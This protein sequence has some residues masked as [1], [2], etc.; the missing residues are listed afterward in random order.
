MAAEVV[1]WLE[2]EGWDVYQEVSGPSGVCDIVAIRDGRCRVVEAKLAMGLPVLHQ[3]NGWLP[4]AHEVCVAVPACGWKTPP[5]F[6][7]GLTVAR[8]FGF[9]VVHVCKRRGAR[10]AVP[11]KEQDALYV[12]KLTKLLHPKMKTFSP[13]GTSSGKRYTP[14]KETA[15]RVLAYVTANPGVDIQALAQG[16]THHYKKNRTF[17]QCIPKLV[18]QGAVPGVKVEH[19]EKAQTLR[20]WPVANEVAQGSETSRRRAVLG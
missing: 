9:G 11:P 18:V 5:A 1:K 4:F 12:S 17:V 3:A 7:F 19:D 14:F 16:C 15:E 13:A 2:R 10:F 20:L 6:R 8:K